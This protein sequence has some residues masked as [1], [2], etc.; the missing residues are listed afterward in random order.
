MEP[1]RNAMKDESKVSVISAFLIIPEIIPIKNIVG[2]I[3][4]ASPE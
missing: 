2:N 3:M 4:V 1:T